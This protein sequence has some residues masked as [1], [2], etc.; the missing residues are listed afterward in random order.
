MYTF[1]YTYLNP[2]Y[3]KCK[4]YIKTWSIVSIWRVFSVQLVYY[5]CFEWFWYFVF[6]GSL[7]CR[8]SIKNAADLQKKKKKLLPHACRK[9]YKTANN[10]IFIVK[11]TNEIYIVIFYSFCWYQWCIFLISCL[12]II[13]LRF[14]GHIFKFIKF[15]LVVRVFTLGSAL[16]FSS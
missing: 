16:V 12:S 4:K 13:S 1:T 11:I 9:S 8:T 14:Y 5:V 10:L 3:A 15:I 6:F 7:L 2:K